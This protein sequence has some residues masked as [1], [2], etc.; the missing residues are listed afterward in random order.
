MGILNP[1]LELQQLEA[2]VFLVELLGE[3]RVTASLGRWKA[4]VKK[5]WSG[6]KAGRMGEWAGP[7]EEE[8][9]APGGGVKSTVT[10]CWGE[11]GAVLVREKRR[12]SL[13]T[14]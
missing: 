9:T 7:E 1:L 2:P 11:W 10:V 12:G 8:G 14:V 4:G 6:L 3:E 13:I 5:S